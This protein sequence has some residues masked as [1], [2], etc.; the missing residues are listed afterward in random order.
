MSRLIYCPFTGCCPIRVA[1]C[2]NSVASRLIVTYIIPFMRERFAINIDYGELVGE[3]LH[4]IDK[5]CERELES[6]RRVFKNMDVEVVKA[7]D[8]LPKISYV[9]KMGRYNGMVSSLKRIPVLCSDELPNSSVKYKV[10]YRFSEAAVRTLLVFAA[11]YAIHKV[12]G[13]KMV[14]DGEQVID[15]FLKQ[16]SNTWRSRMR[17]TPIVIEGIELYLDWNKKSFVTQLKNLL[18]NIASREI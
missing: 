6:V 16:L 8:V 11:M 15:I 18:L 14:V 12:K 10:N 13:V 3:L 4:S 9:M 1:A 5:Y 17:Q 2:T 7:C